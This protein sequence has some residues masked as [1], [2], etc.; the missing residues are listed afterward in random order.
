[1][2]ASGGM[3]PAVTLAEAIYDHGLVQSLY[4]S[5]PVA[6][7][8][9][10]Y[11]RLGTNLP[12]YIPSRT[13]ASALFDLLF[14]DKAAQA[15]GE[16]L[17]IGSAGSAGNLPSMLTSLSRLPASKGKEAI[18]T[19]VKQSGGDMPRTLAAFERWYDDGMD[20]AAGWYKR[21]T[22]LVLFFLG[23]GIAVGLN[24][25]SITV[26]RSLWINP[27]LRSYAVT[28]AEQYA[29]AQAAPSAEASKDLSVLQT[30]A[31]PIG[32]DPAKY[33]WMEGHGQGAAYRQAFSLSSLIFVVAGWLLTAVAMTVGA[34][35][36]FDLLNQFMVVRST[37]KPREKSDVET[38][39]DPSKK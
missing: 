8:T 19:L 10:W 26:G 31:L 3:A 28:T 1:M 16:F 6:R 27:A 13:F 4:R 33:P 36:W 2:T 29:R 5:G 11:R 18:V 24:V 37:I 32:W 22:Q 35:F 15:G 38:S 14:P 17:G 7:A 25:D 12:S 20:R 39:K 9:P 30:L 21:K 23:L 34:P